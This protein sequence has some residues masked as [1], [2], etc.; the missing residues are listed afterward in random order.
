[1]D[2]KITPESVKGSWPDEHSPKPHRAGQQGRGSVVEA[3]ENQVA[4]IRF[5][6]PI[7]IEASRCKIPA[8]R[9]AENLKYWVVTVVAG[10]DPAEL[11]VAIDNVAA[12]SWCQRTRIIVL[13]SAWMGKFADGNKYTATRLDEIPQ[14]CPG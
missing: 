5:Q 13:P 7:T 11:G 3:S 12:K 9:G 6:P 10:Q 1:M 8:A 4:L 14:C 2:H